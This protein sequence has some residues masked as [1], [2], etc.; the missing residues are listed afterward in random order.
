[1]AC[2]DFD[3]A[4]QMLR[5]AVDFAEIERDFFSLR[6]WV[7]EVELSGHNAQA[8]E[9]RL[10]APA[11]QEFL[12]ATLQTVAM[13]SLSSEEA[14]SRLRVCLKSGKKQKGEAE[15]VTQYQYA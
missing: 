13:G 2:Y 4:I 6:K 1:M 10:N 7:N 9:A 8:I 3:Y 5:Q 12:L 11:S 14:L 15:L